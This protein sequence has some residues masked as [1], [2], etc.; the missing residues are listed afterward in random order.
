MPTEAFNKHVELDSTK[1]PATLIEQIGNLSKDVSIEF[2]SDLYQLLGQFQLD[3]LQRFVTL[4]SNVDASMRSAFIAFVV[5]GDDPDGAF[6][7]YLDS[8]GECQEAVDLAFAAH[9]GSLRDL[10]RSLSEAE[11]IVSATN[12]EEI[13]VICSSAEKALDEMERKIESGDEAPCVHDEL[14]AVRAAV[15]ALAIASTSSTR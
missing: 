10:G 3:D 1:I 12:S 9:V 14:E 7:K 8:N 2:H 15:K 4:W 13:A 11:Q 5:M 6:L